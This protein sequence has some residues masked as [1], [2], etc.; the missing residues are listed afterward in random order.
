M[1]QNIVLLDG[2]NFSLESI[3]E[4]FHEHKV[5]VGDSVIL[6][7]QASAYPLPKYSWMKDGKQLSINRF[8]TIIGGSIE[9]KDFKHSDGGKYTC[10]IN[11]DLKYSYDTILEVKGN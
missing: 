5:T 11:N 9:I 10:I 1:T 7:C 8:K 2:I 4:P 3:V 6:N